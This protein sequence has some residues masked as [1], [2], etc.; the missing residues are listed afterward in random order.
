MQQVKTAGQ[1]A[2]DLGLPNGWTVMSMGIAPNRIHQALYFGPGHM[3]EP[4]RVR[5]ETYEDLLVK[6][7]PYIELKQL[8]IL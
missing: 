2:R 3:K 4:L 8:S 1:A 7:R 5:S 6:L